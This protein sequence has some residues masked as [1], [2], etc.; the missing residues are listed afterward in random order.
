MRIHDNLLE[1]SQATN[2]QIENLKAWFND[3]NPVVTEEA[4]YFDNKKEELISLAGKKSALHRF[5]DSHRWLI[6]V[7]SI[8]V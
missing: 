6:K 5:V 3:H 2:R 8:T 7:F 4:T 1:H